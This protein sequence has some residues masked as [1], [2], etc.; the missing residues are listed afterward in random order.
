[1]DKIS[2]LALLV[3]VFNDV[4]K[5]RVCD[6]IGGLWI[7]LLSDTDLLGSWRAV[8]LLNLLLFGGRVAVF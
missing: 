2:L 8:K 1:M 4:G 3:L 6:D 5:Y 7:T